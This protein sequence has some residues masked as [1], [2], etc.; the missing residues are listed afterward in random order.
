MQ[1][2]STFDISGIES[3]VRKMSFDGLMNKDLK[4]LFLY[5][6]SLHHII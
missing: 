6:F 5:I 3:M 2:S 4:S 1:Q